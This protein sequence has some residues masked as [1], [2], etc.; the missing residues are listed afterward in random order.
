MRVNIVFLF[1]VCFSISGPGTAQVSAQET[2]YTRRI[3]DFTPISTNNPIIARID[4]SIEIPVSEYLTY[5]KA[6]HESTIKNKLDLNQKKEILNDLIDEYLIVDEA[7]RIGADKHPGFTSRM[8]FTRTM[9]LSEF[10]VEQEV[11]AKAKTAGEYNNLLDKLQNRLFDAATINVSIGDYDR[12][13]QAA[14]EI[15]ATDKPSPQLNSG[16]DVQK[17]ASSAKAKIR[18][19]MEN[20][21]DSVLARY[22]DTTMTNGTPITVKQ[23]LAV[24][25]NLHAPRPPLETDEDLINMIKPFIMPSLMA[26]EAVKQGIEALPAFQN[27][28]IENRSALLRIYM[29]GVIEAQANKELNAPGL[30][31]RVKSWYQQN[32]AQYAIQATNGVK[33]IPTYEQIQ[34]RVEGDYSV[35]LRDQIQAEKVSALRK[36]RHVEI[37]EAVLNGL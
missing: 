26:D 27:K 11:D 32:A 6:E 33:T 18:E 1:A 31:K 34:K 5:Q 29:H 12:L 14:K 37:N 23:V 21:P 8:E 10:L 25:S 30:D 13:R 22:S 35:D 16:A 15:D 24:Y 7:Y 36:T 20:M 3:F 19:I 4:R 28:I 9:L 2:N 17:T